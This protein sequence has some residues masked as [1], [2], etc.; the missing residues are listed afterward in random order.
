MKL[1]A[2]GILAM[3]FLGCDS[4]DELVIADVANCLAATR[5]WKRIVAPVNNPERWAPVDQIGPIVR[6]LALQEAIDEQ[7]PRF[8][9][10]SRT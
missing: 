8:A 5:S 2:V 6:V 10:P 9:D 1:V 7:R 4:L 3:F